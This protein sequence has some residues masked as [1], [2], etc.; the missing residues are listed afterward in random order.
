MFAA[1]LESLPKRGRY[2]DY[3]T[4][5]GQLRPLLQR[6]GGF[7]DNERFESGGRCPWALASSCDSVGSAVDRFASHAERRVV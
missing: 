4:L 5:A 6:I 1:I 2:D 3:L 7:V